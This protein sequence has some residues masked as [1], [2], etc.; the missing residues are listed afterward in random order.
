M[1]EGLVGK[2]VYTNHSFGSSGLNLACE[3]LLLGARGGDR[4]ETPTKL[5]LTQPTFVFIATVNILACV[6]RDGRPRSEA[7]PS[8]LL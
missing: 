4:R 1:R 3:G 2:S 5:R 7:E 6:C 8:S